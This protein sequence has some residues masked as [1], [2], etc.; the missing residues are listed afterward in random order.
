[1]AKKS[2]KLLYPITSRV[3]LSVIKKAY[4]GNL[5]AKHYMPPLTEQVVLDLYLQVLREEEKRKNEAL[6][7]VQDHHD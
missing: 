4:D 5:K 6:R 2:K 7:T 1:M 3:P